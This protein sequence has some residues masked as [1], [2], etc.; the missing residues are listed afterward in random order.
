MRVP[1]RRDM[2]RALIERRFAT[3]ED[4]VVAWEERVA[5]RIQRNGK[6]RSRA[7]IYRWLDEGLPSNRDD[8]FGF[9]GVLDVDPV[10]LVDIT[11]E[12]IR[13][14][15][16]RERRLFQLGQKARSPI[17]AFWSIY[18]PGAGWPTAT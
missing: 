8:I 3:V 7:A 17:S 6:A 12:Y 4:L 9:A 16:A 13:E 1:L 14:T 5:S 2:V 11:D 15:Y 18:I 10:A